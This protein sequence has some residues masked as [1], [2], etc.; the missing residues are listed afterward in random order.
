MVQNQMTPSYPQF[1]Q[2]GLEEFQQQQ[3]QTAAGVAV[4]QAAPGGGVPTAVSDPS[5][6]QSFKDQQAAQA[7]LAAGHP[8]VTANGV[9]QQTVRVIDLFYDKQWNPLLG[10]N[11]DFFFFCYLP[12]LHHLVS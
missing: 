10:T 6:V 7:A 12:W 2:T 4:S 9:E 8:P 3:Q 1:T 5:V 11:H